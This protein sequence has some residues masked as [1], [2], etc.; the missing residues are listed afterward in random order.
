MI[1]VQAFKQSEQDNEQQG[2]ETYSEDAK[3]TAEREKKQRVARY[4]FFVLFAGLILYLKSFLPVG[5]AQ[6]ASDGQDESHKPETSDDVVAAISDDEAEARG[7]SPEPEKNEDEEDAEKDEA[8]PSNVIPFS[9]SSVYDPAIDGFMAS[10][11]P[12]FEFSGGRR[13]NLPTLGSS[14]SPSIIT[15]TNDNAAP[16][17]A[18]ATSTGGDGMGPGGPHPHD[19][20]GPR[21]DDDEPV[22]ANRAPRVN[23]VIRL[24]DMVGFHTYFIS[25]AVLLTG[26][27]DPDGD[28][29]SLVGLNASSGTLTPTQGGW[30]FDAMPG[31]LGQITFTY[32]I[33]DGTAAV[34]QQAYLKVVAEP[35]IAGTDGHD[36]ILGTEYEDDIDAGDGDD[37]IDARGGNDVIRGGSGNDHII[38]GAGNDV[39]YAG[40]GDDIVY[41]GAGNDIVFAGC[42]NDRIFGEQG[43]DILF[44]EEG[45]DVLDGGAGDDEL[46][47]AAGNDQLHGADGDDALDG[48]E[49]DD[50]L[51][52]GAGNDVLMAG[53]GNDKVSGGT[54]DD[55]ITDGAGQD[56]VDG[57][58]GNDYTLA[59]IDQ[60][61]D[62]YNGGAD[63]DT[64]DYSLAT[65]SVV[66]DLESGKAEG[67]EIGSDTVSNYEHV[68]TGSG[69]D[70]I[71][72][73]EHAVAMTGGDGKDT[74]EFN[75]ARRSYDS[76]DDG[77]VVGKITDFTVGDR[78]IVADYEIRYKDD[79]S[80][81]TLF[82][83][84][85][86]AFE[87]TYFVDAQD[88][89]PVRFRFE[90]IDDKDMTI[91]EVRDA[92]GDGVID[93]YSVEIELSGR[94]HLEV[95]VTTV[96]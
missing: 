38:A 44:G 14:T 30:S 18:S 40:C 87:N 21:D 37:N 96:P 19:P 27:S 55:F 84:I 66:V 22:Q 34:R 13:N 12:A 53:T 71:T 42:G 3:K 43:N 36:N 7:R 94:H 20:H 33:S 4:G 56:D 81:K 32:W 5:T 76:Q 45:D 58:A 69:N 35:P 62:S 68:I 2:A 11:S 72:A 46:F 1:K 88:Q 39:V 93:T 89:R 48:G 57:G 67:E 52:G 6:T 8:E 65:Q 10:D 9:A 60:A 29:L 51:D 75:N 91:V 70:H 85:E 50:D 74:F 41:A 90:K 16:Q 78:L 73:G 80:N 54:G 49:G 24:Q 82:K 28:T 25:S 83:E 15:P 23:S 79:G 63:A 47:G 86:N 77:L 59:A 61:N 95:T 26:A 64:L 31:V 17:L 92:N